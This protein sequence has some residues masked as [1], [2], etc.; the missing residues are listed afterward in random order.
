MSQPL[1]ATMGLEKW[2][3]LALAAAVLFLAWQTVQPF[4]LVL[5]AAGIAAIML[6]P[7]H[8]RMERLIRHRK[9]AAFLLVCG[10]FLLVALP[11]FFI[12]LLM[13]KQASE[14]LQSSLGEA[15]WLATFD[16]RSHPLFQS[17]PAFVQ[18]QVRAWDLHALARNLAQWMFS[19]V[20]DLFS[21]TTRLVLNTFIFF[22]ALYYILVDRQKMY[23]E[24]L[25]LSPFG[26]AMDRDI[27]H[28]IVLTVRSVVFGAV[29]L[30]FV[31]GVLAAIGMS[32]F[33]VPGAL[34]WGA[35]TVVAAQVPLFG[36]GLVMIPAVLY[37]FFTGSTGAA[38]GLLIWAAVFVGLS[39]NVLAPYLI[40]GATHMHA[41]L[42]LIFI[43]GGLE[44]F[45]SI[46]IIVGPVILAAFL[47]VIEL[48]KAGMLRGGSVPPPPQESSST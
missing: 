14:I 18:E 17:L 26:D 6:T 15:G 20:G 27:I 34:I 37:L 7:L 22:I 38:I 24:I 31:Q 45:G 36:V 33:G 21:S 48:Y 42:V 10:V 11:V 16:P 46:G 2:F 47:V 25:A 28:R 30:A 12:L 19:N 1:S 4:V 35:I 39:D 29:I 5:L 40:K 32:I 43:F 13:V 44:V 8:V 23:D 41:F 3:F 9:L